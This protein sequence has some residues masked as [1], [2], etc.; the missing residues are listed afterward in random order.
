VSTLTSYT[1][2]D[3]LTS[4]SDF[5]FKM[6]SIQ[7]NEDDPIP[8]SKKKWE[9]FSN[10]KRNKTSLRS[11]FQNTGNSLP[12]PPSQEYNTTNEYESKTEH[13]AS[14]NITTSFRCHN[15]FNLVLYYKNDVI[16]H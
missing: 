13:A 6:D 1:L 10:D 11:Y 3:A 7:W 14:K 2:L 15:A 16:S 8:K 4:N 9:V 12:L 5:S